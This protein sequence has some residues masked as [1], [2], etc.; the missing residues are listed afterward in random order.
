MGARNSVLSGKK[1]DELEKIR[2]RPGGKKR[3]QLKHIVW[4][5][6]ELDRFG[7]AESLL[8][9][10]E[11]CQKILSVLAPLV[12]TGSENLKS[13]YNTVCVLWCIHAEEKVKHTEEAK[14]IVQRHL[15]VE[16]GTA[17]KMPAT[18][19]PTAPPSGKGGNY[20]VQQI[21][22]NYTHL[23]LSPRTLNAW[24]K[25]IEEKKFGAEVVPGFQALSEGCTPYDINQMLNCVG[26]HQAAMQI[27]RE[28]INEEA[29]DWDLQ[30]PQPGPIPPGQLREPRGSDIAGTTSTVDE[31][32]QWMYRQQNPI[33][34]GNIYRRWIQLGLQKCVRM[35]NPTNILDVKQGP[36]EPFQSYVDRFYKSLRA[37]Q[38]D[39]AVKNWMTQ[40]LL[41]QNANPD[42]KLVLKGLGINP[43]LEEMLTACQGVGGPGQKA[44]LMAEALKDALTQGPLPFAAVQQKGQRKIIKCWNCGKEGHSAR[45][46]RAPR[47]QGCWKCGKAGHVMAKCPER[48]AGFFRA[49]PMGKE[50]PQFPHGPDAS[51]ADTNCSPRGS[52][53]GST[54]ELHED[55]QKA[56]GEQRETLQGGNG[57]FAAPQFSLWRRPIVTAYIEEQPVEVLLDTGADDSIVAG[58][59]LGPN[60]TPKIVGGIGGFIN[61]KEYKDVKIK[62]LGKVIK[63][64]IMTGDTPINI[65]G[66]NL[67]TAMGMS[68]NLP[69]A[70]VEPIKVTLKPG[71]DGPKL[72]QWPL[73]KEKIIALREI[74]EK[75]EKDGQ[76]EEAPPTNPYNTP[77]FAIKKK[78]KNKWRMLIDFRELNKVTQDFTEVQLGIPHPAGLAKRRRITVLDVGDAYFS[79]PLDE[80]FRQ[81]TAFTLPSVNNAEPGKR[82]IYKV[83]PQ[84]WKGS[85]AIFQHTMR[86][87]LEPFRKANPDVTL[88]QY[89][90]DILIA[91]DRTDLEHDRVVLQLKELLN[92]IGFSTPEE[93]FQKDPPFQWMGY[94]L[95]PTKWK[96]QKIELP[97]RET[98]TVNDI[99]KLVGV[100]NWAAQIYPGIK[101]KHLC[102]LI[103]GKMT[104]TEEVQWTE[105]AEAEYEENK[106]I[107]SQEQEG[108]YYQEGKPLEATVIKSQDNQWS[109][110]IHQEDKILKV[111]K[112]AK[113]KNTHTNGVRLLAHVVQKIGKEA[114]VI[115][116]QVPRFHLPVEREIWEQW[117][118]D[119]WQVTWIPE[120]DFVST[121]P[122]VRL[123]FNLVKEPIQGAET[124]Y[125][126]GSC[127]RQSREGKA[128]Y[129]TDRGRDKAKLLEQTTNQQAELEA[130]YLA[131]A[132]SGPKANIIVDSQYVMGIVAGQPTE[133]ESR[134]VNQIIEEMIKKEAIYVAWVPAHKGIGGNQEVDH[135]VSQGIRQVLFLEKIEPAQEEHEKYHSNVK[136]LVF[137]FGLPRLVAKQIVDTCDKCHQKG[138]AIHGQVNAELGTWQMDCTHLEGKIIIVAVH[139]A[140]G[141]IEAEVI[142]QETGRQTALFLLKLASRWP[143]T[144]LH[145][146]NGANFTSQEVKMVAWWAGIEQTFGVPYN[147][148]SQGVVE[149]MNHHLKTQIDRIRE[150]ANS[151]ETIVLMAVHCMNF[152]RRGGIGDMTPAERLVN[153]ITTEQEIQ[154]QQSKNSK[155][156]NFRVYYREGRD[157][158]WKG[159]GELLWKGEGAV[160]LKVGTEIKVVPRR[161]AKIIKDY[162]GGKELDSGSHLEDTGEAREVA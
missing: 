82:Y 78:D 80:E 79:I 155:F 11:G 12:P 89:M 25:L 45:Q 115:W 75:M 72:R 161:K 27:I 102:R 153:M 149:A 4:A 123:V 85:P 143:I 159:P 121:P 141:F 156:K 71:K 112:F 74:C 41:I 26:E 114:I 21:G 136:E 94:E 106:I 38:T 58:I 91:S 150:Q 56:E 120:W 130:F 77:T 51:G 122:L 88:I 39:P 40:T 140:S 33:P 22:G 3:Y 47:R 116:G 36:K 34:V 142:P 90:D 105:M 160:I 5:A 66:R 139:V 137:K 147:P 8:E 65:F 55:G 92:S 84:G 81:Y 18:S 6:N 126:D 20:P 59:E 32:I 146:D 96:L 100:L 97:Q 87:V 132:D 49:W 104:L 73:S 17:D 152:K 118:T 125:V 44:R 70:K 46:C 109:Y 67:L 63:G 42:C 24:V 101:T 10:K 7:L 145:T 110:K 35:Y 95:W 60:Y 64:T 61:T 50:A 134:L 16:T 138:E 148:Q 43:T 53:C 93:K 15:V 154:F 131:L 68:L 14:Q 117:W 127:N 31:Q 23:P 48:Q 158:L 62:V 108:C 128:G 1:A 144:H 57:G 98:W 30:H 13:L 86:N 2:L 37:E 76:L 99:Q 52:S 9:N 19:R 83:L 107:L 119:Y 133:S 103:R 113:I 124:F 162:G 69:I 111:G 28:I 54:E 151:I 157:Q 135:L 129:V 29:A